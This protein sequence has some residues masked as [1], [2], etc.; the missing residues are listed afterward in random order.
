M[1]IAENFFKMSKKFIYELTPLLWEQTSE[2]EV[3]NTNKNH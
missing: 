1:K 2:N 3:R